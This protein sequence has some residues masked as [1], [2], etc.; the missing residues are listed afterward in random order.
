[1]EARGQT[2]VFETPEQLA[3]VGPKAIAAPIVKGVEGSDF[4][5]ITGKSIEFAPTVK[6]TIPET[7]SLDQVKNNAMRTLHGQYEPL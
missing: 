7:V 6:E 1:M 4:T 5:K 2:T 3:A